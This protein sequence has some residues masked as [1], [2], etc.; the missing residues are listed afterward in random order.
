[1]TTTTAETST[2]LTPFDYG[3]DAVDVGQVAP[4]YEG[5]TT[6]D[7][8]LAFIKLLQPGSPEVA[9]QS[10]PGAAA[11]VY[12][13]KLNGRM[14]KNPEGILW[15]SAST[16][17][18]Y[19]Q[20]R[21][22]DN[23]GGIQGRFSIDSPEVA[24]AKSASKEFGVY[25]IPAEGG[26]D[27]FDDLVETFYSFGI[28]LDEDYNP[29]NAG[30]MTFVSSHIKPYRAWMSQIRMHTVPAPGGGKKIP[31]MYSH[32]CRFTSQM[33]EKGDNVYFVPVFAPAIEGSISKSMLAPDSEAFKLARGVY[34]S[35][36]AGSA[37]IDYSQED[38]TGGDDGG[39][40]AAKVF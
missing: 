39:E 13:N 28:C 7:Q 24:K 27:G 8:A 20:W 34:E 21:H 40:P 29:L 18:E 17:H 38:G 5:Q 6:D 37:K 10:V 32:L 26:K 30:I 19:V 2:E 1:M 31:P 36:K 14:W 4:G 15:V 11:G 35:I 3:D 23:G 9:K 25:Q 12:L 33:K 22:K 16:K